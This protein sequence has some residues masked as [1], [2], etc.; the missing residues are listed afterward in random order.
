[1]PVTASAALDL[2]FPDDMD[3]YSCDYGTIAL[4]DGNSDN[5]FL[6]SLTIDLSTAFVSVGLLHVDLYNA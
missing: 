1:M 5:D 4:W 3:M 6:A 2:T